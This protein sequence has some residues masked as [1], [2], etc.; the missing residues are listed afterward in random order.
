MTPS[1]WLMDGE[2][3]VKFEKPDVSACFQN[4]TKNSS[5]TRNSVDSLHCAFSIR[6]SKD[7][8]KVSLRRTHCTGLVIHRSIEQIECTFIMCEERL[9]FLQHSHTNLDVTLRRSS[10]PLP[11]AASTFCRWLLLN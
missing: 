6:S 1:E 10:Q 5:S 3:E 8:N 2:Q 7:D 4:E 11:F 9:S